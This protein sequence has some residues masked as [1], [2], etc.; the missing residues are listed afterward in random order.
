MITYCV[1]NCHCPL[2]IPK[3]QSI[4][5]NLHFSELWKDG[6]YVATTFICCQ[7]M[8]ECRSPQNGG[9]HQWGMNIYISTNSSSVGKN[10]VVF[11][12]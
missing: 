6:A 1:E 4:I 8:F 11:L 10:F 12:R 5:F 3:C 2:V 9:R 7:R